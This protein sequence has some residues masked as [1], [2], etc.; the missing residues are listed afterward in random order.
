MGRMQPRRTGQ[1]LGASL[2]AEVVRERLAAR[3]PRR[4][5][6]DEFKRAAVLVPILL[7]EAGPELLLTVRSSTLRSHAGQIAFPGGRLEPGEDELS[8]ALRETREEVGLAVSQGEVVGRLSDHPS[9]AGYVATPVVA[10]LS[11]PRPLALDPDEVAE[12]F[13]VPLADLA[14]LTPASRV[15]NLLQYRRRIYSY[16]WRGR[17]IWGFT[18]NVV[19]ELLSALAGGEGT[20]DDPFEP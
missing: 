6:I 16:P 8:A 15:G 18:G 12:A 1:E 10:V 17:D 20:G 5:Q 14:A 7:S 3:D 9:P 2:S 4:M 19:F 11:W 13:T